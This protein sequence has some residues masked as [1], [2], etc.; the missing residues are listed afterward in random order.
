MNYFFPCKDRAKRACIYFPGV[1][2]Q[3]DMAIVA[4]GKL[5]E[6][7]NHLVL[8]DY[9]FV[10]G[11]ETAGPHHELKVIHDDMLDV[12]NINRMQHRLKRTHVTREEFR[13]IW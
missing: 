10:D 13:K 4:A 1:H 2:H 6:S 11:L 8:L 3:S 5:P 7:F 9:S 12:V